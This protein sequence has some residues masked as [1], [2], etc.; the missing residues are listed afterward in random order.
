[1]FGIVVNLV[2]FRLTWLYFF[3]FGH[4]AITKCT[5]KLFGLI[6]N[7]SWPKSIFFVLAEIH[8]N[9]FYFFYYIEQGLIKDLYP[10]S[11]I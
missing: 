2:L 11:Q 1:M 6:F 5:S 9:F 10:K 3:G 7:Q 4:A 8:T